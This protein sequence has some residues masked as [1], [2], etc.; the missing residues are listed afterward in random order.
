M[1]GVQYRLTLDVFRGT[2][3]HYTASWP[4]SVSVEAGGGRG[5]GS[6]GHGGERGRAGGRGESAAAAAAAAGSGGNVEL[7]PVVT[8]LGHGHYSVLVSVE[9]EW[10]GLPAGEA[11]LGARALPLRVTDAAAATETATRRG[12]DGDRDRDRDSK[13]DTESNRDKDADRDRDR[14]ADRGSDR[15]HRSSATETPQT[16]PKISA[17]FEW[18]LLRCRA[19]STPSPNS[20]CPPPNSA[21][22]R[23]VR[24]NGRTWVVMLAVDL[25]RGTGGGEGSTGPES[26]EGGGPEVVQHVELKSQELAP[27][28]KDGG[29]I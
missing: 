13:R 14:D 8:G 15:D 10:E 2:R 18:M 21:L 11:M 9:D 1:P 19:I 25:D 6:G 4:V 5:G 22:G 17:G 23:V 29:E 7:A 28:E 24:K 12:G 26:V 27:V 3:L 16:S 20:E